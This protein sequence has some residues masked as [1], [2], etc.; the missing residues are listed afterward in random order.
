MIDWILVL[1]FPL[2]SS[3]RILYTSSCHVDI[4]VMPSVATVY[5]ATTMM[6][7]M[8]MQLAISNRMPIDKMPAEVFKYVC[9]I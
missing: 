8:A 3:Y 5:F 7:N 4:A 9:M 2:S 1:K 6:V